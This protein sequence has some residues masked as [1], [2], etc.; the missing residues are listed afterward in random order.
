M[1]NKSLTD[2][3]DVKSKEGKDSKEQEELDKEIQEVVNKLLPK[4]EKTEKEETEEEKTEE[5]GKEIEEQKEIEKLTLKDI[6]ELTGRDFKNR[7]EFIKH[8]KNLASFSGSD[9]AQDLRKKAKEYDKMMEDAKKVE[10]LLGEEEK[11]KEGKK[12]KKEIED[13]RLSDLAQKQLTTEEEITKLKEQ[14]KDA[15]FVKKYPDTVPFLD[16]IKAAANKVEKDIDEFYPGSDIES[17]IV[18]KKAFE[19]VKKKEK[20]L[21]I[22]S[23]PRLAPGRSQKLV[24]LVRQLK[25]AEKDGKSRDVDEIRQ[26]IVEEQLDIRLED[27]K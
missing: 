24:D 10:E 7:D 2:S 12:D 15:E 5:E 3:S 16:V 8:Y 25:E 17:L 20:D 18:N 11:G 26:K 21:G 13:K 19:D 6:N 1:K 4:E 9:E 27:Q 14:L 23:K 22:K